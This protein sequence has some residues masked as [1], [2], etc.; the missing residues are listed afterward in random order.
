MP[1]SPLL[2]YVILAAAAFTAGVFNALAGG[3]SFFSF[4]A[5]LGMGLPPINANA[6]STV[7]L[8]PGH[9]SSLVALRRQLRDVGRASVAVI[10]CAAVGGT[11]GALALLRTRQSVFMKLVP[12]LLF[13]ATAL[14]LLAE[15]ARRWLERRRA[16]RASI[17]SGPKMTPSALIALTL[18]AVYVGYFGAGAAFL[19]YAA[20]AVFGRVTNLYE[21]LAIKTL[22]NAVANA[23]AIA[24]FIVAG[25]VYWR[26]CLVMIAL[27]SLGGYIG[28]VY[29]LRF[30]PVVLRTIVV[31]TGFAFSAYYFWKVY[32]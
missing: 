5:L 29:A 25:A 19:I 1:E 30:R 7:A 2:R 17:S 20:F 6:T 28:S 24:T 14:F 3:G 11:I 32:V 27:A 10:A 26:E 4:P 16:A 12:W 22:C 31:V 13:V 15:P 9:I 21:V 18:V 23:L 8:W